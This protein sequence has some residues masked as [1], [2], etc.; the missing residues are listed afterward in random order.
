MR[1]LPPPL[2][3]VFLLVMSGLRLWAPGPTVLPAPWNGVGLAPLVL[4]A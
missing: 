1:I 3:L 4:G 2:A